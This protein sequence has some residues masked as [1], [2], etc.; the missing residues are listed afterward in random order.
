AGSTV[1][2]YLEL[3]LDDNITLSVNESGNNGSFWNTTGT[4]WRLY[5]NQGAVAKLTAAQGCTI[6]SATFT[7]S[8]TN[9]GTLT[10]KG[11]QLKT[12]DVAEINGTEAEFPVANTGTETKGQVRITAVKVVYTTG[13]APVVTVATPVISGTTPFDDETEVT[14]SC[15]TTGASIYYTLDGST[16]SNQST[17]YTGAFDLNA[18]TTVKAIAYKDNTASSVA[19]KEFVMNA[20]KAQV[21]SLAA[22]NALEDNTEFKF[23]SDLTATGQTGQYLYAQDAT[24][25]TLIYGQAG[26]TYKFGDVIPAGWTGKKVTFR[27]A[28]EMTNMAGLQAATTTAEV[29]VKE[30]TTAEAKDL[31]N[32]SLY[33][34]IKNVTIDLEGKKLV[35][36]DGSDVAYYDRFK[37]TFPE[38][39]EGKK[40][41]VNVI[42]GYYDNPQVYPV[43]FE[44]VVEPEVPAI[45]LRG[46]F[47][48][49]GTTHEFVAGSE[50]GVYTVSLNE[51]SGSF[52]VATED[53]STVNL[54][55]NEGDVLTVGTPYALV[56]NGANLKVDGT[57]KNAVVT[58]NAKEKTVTV[59]GDV[60]YTYYMKHPWG[61]KDWTWKQ[62]TDNGDGTYT[63]VEEYG[64]N[65]VN[66]NTAASDNGA[67]WF[68]APELVNNPQTGDAVEFV[69]NKEENKVTITKIINPVICF[70]V[71]GNF[72]DEKDAYVGSATVKIEGDDMPENSKLQYRI[73]FRDEQL[74]A[75]AED[76][77]PTWADYTEVITLDK[78][79]IVSA[80]IIDATG[81][82]L[83][84]SE[85]EV[86]VVPAPAPAPKYSLVGY[87]NGADYGCEADAANP[88]E[89]IF[90]EEGK[91]TVSFN[92][93]SYVFV[94]LTDNS[95]W[96]LSQAFVPQ[97]E[98]FIGE[99]ATTTATMV[100]GADYGEKMQVPAGEVEI[101][102]T[103]TDEN[104]VVLTYSLPGTKDPEEEAV[105]YVA[106]TFNEWNAADEAFEMTK[107]D[108]GIYELQF[109]VDGD[110]T[111]YEFKVTDGTWNHSWPTS[112]YAFSAAEPS[113]V[114][115]TF[116]PETKEITVTVT[117]HKG[118]GVNDITVAGAKAYKTIEN[119]E[120]II[121][122]DGVKYNVMG[123][124]K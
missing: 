20:P 87:I 7:Y 55:G 98:A 78:S 89:Y 97:A 80:R 86:K 61:G 70:T 37:V 6:V 28:P 21:A 43:A 72:D 75:P 31:A 24:A 118:T 64:S 15:E 91:L 124:K 74:V 105:Y 63:I 38:V 11:N 14:I 81:D 88:G 41:N 8:F 42:T 57:V 16:P 25:G 27:G 44:E 106:G 68:G 47:N 112:N 29:P 65:G 121:V 5:Q 102:L 67:Q 59:T 53:W 103:V 110:E 116:N 104:T 54:G 30:M 73:D 101:T 114:L 119:G 62:L 82:I 34:V 76:D 115:I 107:N 22:L 2:P 60:I 10:F 95:K 33:G 90:N 35:A 83:D 77:E 109:T 52:K 122:K 46:D 51:L 99:T 1:T 49:W 23:I 13:S 111:G 9:T 3:S 92:E 117:P 85:V 40:F 12:G 4:Q 56:E 48:E 39:V 123:Q 32:F 66:V 17:Q 84:S 113:D 71:E 93:T 79:A 94:K 69:Y 45:Y 50:D 26:Q 36:E 120:V 19:T 58:Y 96:F 108:N 18:T 100:N